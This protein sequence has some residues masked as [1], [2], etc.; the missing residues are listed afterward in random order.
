MN[1]HLSPEVRAELLLD[2]MKLDQKIQ[3][4]GNSPHP[5]EK[6]A[7]CEFTALGRHI[8]GIPELA[9]PTY[10]AIN[11]GNGI[12]G[13]DCLPEPIATGL[14]SATMSAATFNRA[15]NFAWGEVLGQEARDVAHHVLL[16]PGLNLIRHPYTGR[17]QE[18]MG[19]DPYLC[20]AYEQEAC[21]PPPPSGAAT[22]DQEALVAAIATAAGNKTVVVLKTSGMV[23]MP[24]LDNVRALLEAWFPGQADG[25]VVADILFGVISPSGKLPVTFGNT[26]PRGRVRHR[27]PISWRPR[28]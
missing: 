8:E 9:I 14:P 19:E 21:V 11:G 15:I 22:T 13:G 20:D 23:L 6:L 2:A 3:Q 12:R 27:S 18:Y 5:N 16:G 24:W 7:G 26:P 1:T 28:E 17:G 4:M 25:D 10:R